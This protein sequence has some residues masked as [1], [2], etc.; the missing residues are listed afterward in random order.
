MR[1]I[2][3]Q[4]LIFDLTWISKLQAVSP[5][6]D[7]ASIIIGTNDFLPNQQNVVRRIQISMRVAQNA[8]KLELRYTNA[9]VEPISQSWSRIFSTILSARIA[10][11][12]LLP[13]AGQV[14]A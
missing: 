2:R 7:D 1:A 4:Q 14:S 5:S 12:Q 11:A 13:A 10:L 9:L 8:M 3:A 6:A